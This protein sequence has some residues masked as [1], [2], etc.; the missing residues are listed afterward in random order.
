[1]PDPTTAERDHAATLRWAAVA[2]A[3]GGVLLALYPALRPYSDETTLDGA[4]A[5]ASGRWALSHL[6]GMLA[7]I[8]MPLGL[9]G[10]RAAVDGTPGRRPLTAAF[11]T[12]W[13]GAGLALP[14]YGGEVFGLQAISEESVRTGDTELLTLADSVRMDAVPAT[15]FSVAMLL[16]A[17]TGVLVALAVA[18]SG[19]TARWLGLPF[20]AALVLYLPQFFGG[21]PLRIAHGVLAAVGFLLLARWLLT[22]SPR[23]DA[24]RPAPPA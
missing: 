17:A 4:N 23:G 18:R 6:A 2:L 12:A 11:L 3:T 24:E 22:G 13:F 10:L 1:M 14:Y 9:I 21:P 5:M 19:R 15:V 16:F 8:L 7:F 20:G